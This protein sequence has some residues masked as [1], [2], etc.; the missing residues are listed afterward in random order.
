MKM[1]SKT[2]PLPFNPALF[3]LVDAEDGRRWRTLPPKS[4]EEDTAYLQ[5]ETWDDTGWT[6]TLYSPTSTV[7]HDQVLLMENFVKL[8]VYVPMCIE[9]QL[10]AAVRDLISTEQKIRDVM[11]PL[12]FWAAKGQT[13]MQQAKGGTHVL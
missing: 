3:G 12:R 13:A 4:K 10:E 6:V 9:S 5:I 11:D 2:R 8:S 1:A 7:V